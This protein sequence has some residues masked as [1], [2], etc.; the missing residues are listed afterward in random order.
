MG[1]YKNLVFYGLFLTGL[2]CACSSGTASSSDADS[3]DLVTW[4]S[5]APSP[6]SFKPSYTPETNPTPQENPEAVPSAESNPEQ[7]SPPGPES[8]EEISPD[9]T[10]PPSSEQTQPPQGNLPL[11]NDAVFVDDVTIPDMTVL[12]PGEDFV[13]TWRMKNTGTCK[14]TTSY[15]IGFSHGE[16]MKGYDTKLP[17]DVSPG[18]TVDVS[19]NMTAPMTMDWHG[20]FWRLKSDT[21]NSFGDFV[22]VSILVADNKLTFTP[23]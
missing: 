22:Y 13:K 6:S 5:A 8:P 18:G 4:T 19:V 16:R 2:L 14:W 7:E 10:A 21:G 12:F 9:S 15:A 3:P 17:H 23:G 11:C 20:G 1:T